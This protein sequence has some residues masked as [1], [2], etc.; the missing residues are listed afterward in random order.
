M[1]KRISKYIA[2]FGYFDK[3]LI[4]LCVTKGSISNASFATFIGTPVGMASASFSL[5]F[6]ISTGFVN[7]LLK[8]TRS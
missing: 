5:A 2:S 8:T 6:S 4:V 3:P 1:S 7:K